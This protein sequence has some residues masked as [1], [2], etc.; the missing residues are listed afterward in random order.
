MARPCLLLLALAACQPDYKVVPA[1]DE[2]LSLTILSPGYGEYV[3]AAAIELSGVVSPPSAQVLVDGETVPVAEDGSFAVSVPFAGQRALAVHVEAID[4]DEHLHEVVAAFDGV[5]PRLSDPGAITGLLTPSGLDAMEPRLAEAVDS[6]GWTDQILSALPAIESDW[7]DIVPVSVAADPTTADLAPGMNALDLAVTLNRVAIT[8]NVGLLDSLAFDVEV[9]VGTITV[10]AAATPAVDEDGMLTLTLS[11]AV[12]EVND[13]D[14]TVS[15][16]DLDWVGDYLI[17]PLTD[18]V[19]GLGDLLLDLLLDGL[20]T[21]ELGGPF[22]FEADLLGT[23][24][25]ARL[26]SVEPSLDGVGLGATVSTDG[27]AADV[28]P[29]LAPL[30]ATTPSGLD[31]QLGL[32]VHEGL[33]NTVIDASIGGLFDLDLTLTGEYADLLGGGIRALPGGSELPPETEGYCIGVH[34]GDA[35]VLRFDA[36]QGQPLARVWMPDLRFSIQTQSGG[37]CSPWLD[38]SVFATLELNL[39]GSEVSADLEVPSVIVLQYGAEDVDP[40]ELGAA[41]GQLIESMV[42]LFAGTLS[43]DLGDALGGLPFEV[44]PQVVSVE[45]LDEAG[46]YGIYLDLFPA[47]AE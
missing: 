43:F 11:D 5:D 42:G 25:A 8:S 12:V 3:D 10:G 22:A 7:V 20:G 27:E 6:L 37:I 44:D 1:P 15:G 19:L 28:M 26:V 29:E 41:L 17:E 38:A 2:P 46:R 35:R 31:Y 18:L 32:G 36:G 24:V 13:W 16:F 30:V 23:E 34:A 4:P 33:L 40:A 21:L 39:S 47:P 45:P 14:F 9:V